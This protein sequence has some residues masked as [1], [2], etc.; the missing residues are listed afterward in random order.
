[1]KHQLFLGAAITSLLLLG[2]ACTEAPAETEADGGDGGSVDGSGGSGADD[3]SGGGGEGGQG[4]GGQGGQG[5]AAVADNGWV[6]TMSNAADNELIV[7]ERAE[8]GSLTERDRLPTGG[9]GSES[10][11][12]SQGALHSRQVRRTRRWASTHC[13]AVAAR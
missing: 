13:R 7:F 4:A 9:A 1:M 2:S 11:L 8:D 5:G 12:G 6:F 10:G 3:T